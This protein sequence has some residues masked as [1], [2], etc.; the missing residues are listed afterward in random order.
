MRSLLFVPADSERKLSKAFASGADV[1]ILD[2][3][4]AVAADRKPQARE[5][6]RQF[7]S[8]AKGRPG[9]DAPRARLYVRI[10]SLQSDF[11]SADLDGVMPA[12]PDGVFLPKPLSGEDVHRLSIAL[13]HA[14]ERSGIPRGSTRVLTIAEVPIAVF[15]LAT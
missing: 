8:D 14:E 1:L 9:E 4:D 11:W 7:V 2:L 12:K 15:N 3:E 13:N 6:A 10:N 5:M